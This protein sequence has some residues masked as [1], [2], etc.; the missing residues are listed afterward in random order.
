MPGIIILAI[1]KKR[2]FNWKYKG[3][4]KELDI[5][6]YISM[7]LMVIVSAIGNTLLLNKQAFYPVTPD[8]AR[9]FAGKLVLHLIIGGIAYLF[10]KIM[11]FETNEKNKGYKSL[12]SFALIFIILL[13]SFYMPITINKYV[14]NSN[15]SI[16]D[17]EE[18]ED[19]HKYY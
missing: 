10:L 8:F 6:F 1:A 2:Q 7:V 13:S 12:I 11:A 15:S 17:L 4:G 18:E 16:I 9:T 14:N 19:P 3:N 5:I